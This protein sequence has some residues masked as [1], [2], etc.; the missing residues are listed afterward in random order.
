M[1]SEQIQKAIQS[2]VA[3]LGME[4]GEIVL[5]HPG[6]LSHGDYAS[7]V[8]MAL[9]KGAGVKPKDLAEKIATAIRAQNIPEI[10]KV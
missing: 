6:E 10:A 1:I 5:E 3:E 9:A 2:A 4:V 8:A 7:N